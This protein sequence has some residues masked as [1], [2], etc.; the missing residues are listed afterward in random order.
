MEYRLSASGGRLVPVMCALER[1]G[2]HYASTPPTMPAG[3]P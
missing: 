3:E 1:F 2:V